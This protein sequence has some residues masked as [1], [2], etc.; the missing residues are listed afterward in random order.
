LFAK[1]EMKKYHFYLQGGV[2]FDIKIAEQALDKANN[3]VYQLSQVSNN[4]DPVFK[5]VDLGIYGA[6]GCEWKLK[7]THGI[8][9]ALS[10]NKGLMK[11]FNSLNWIPGSS[12]LDYYMNVKFIQVAMEFGYIF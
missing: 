5:S 2:S 4:G 7:N 10:V 8:F 3:Y 1:S 12:K 6:I 9:G 11:Q